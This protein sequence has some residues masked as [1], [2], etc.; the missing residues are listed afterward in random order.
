M[1]QIIPKKVNKMKKWL[2]A[3]GAEI[4]P[5]T[6]PYEVLRFKVPDGTGV[7]YK[8]TAGKCNPGNVLTQ[9]LYDDFIKGEKLKNRPKKKNRVTS[10]RAK[11]QLLA[12]DGDLCFYCGKKMEL[13]DMTEEHLLSLTHGGNNR[14]ENKVLAHK[15]CNGEASHMILKDKLEFAIKKRSQN[16]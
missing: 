10:P 4:L 16:G 14:L 11:K 5:Q 2:A 12:R 1:A 7:I 8:N 13:E 6:N 15:D 9:E 3:Q